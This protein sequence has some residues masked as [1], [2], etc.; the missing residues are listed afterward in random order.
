LEE[1]STQADFWNDPEH[2]QRTMRRLA[3][4]KSEVATWNGTFQRIQDAIELADLGG[5][6]MADDL[7]REA[8]DLHQIVERLAFRAKLSGEYDTEDAYLAIHAGAG[9][10]DAQDWAA[11][12]LRMYL[13]WAERRGYKVEMVS[14]MEGDEAGIK[15]TTVLIQG[16][17]V[18]GYL[19]SERGVHRLV[20]LSPFDSAHRRH[21]SFSLVE[22]WPDVQEE[23]DIVIDEKDLQ[24][25]TFR[26]SG[27]GGQNVQKNSTAVRITHLPT[28]IVVSCQN[29]RSQTQNRERALQ[30]LK[31]RLLDLERQRQEEE[32][33]ELKGEHVSAEWGNAIRSYVLHPYRM[34][35]D[36]RTG[37]ETGNTQAVLDGD[38]D[39]FME[40]Y[41][42]ARVGAGD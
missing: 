11:M 17:Y 3:R 7:A 32:F 36:T 33:A 21:T 24:I 29:E 16:D 23:I 18:Y 6:G 15:S 19:K 2:A 39:Q 22:V 13:R 5:E 38:L 10:V 9:G 40:A 31:T 25:D 20:R 37:Q 34:V 26:S 14:E 1:E 8:D 35:K 42:A 28:G 4:L 27:A 30:V 12:L 41:L